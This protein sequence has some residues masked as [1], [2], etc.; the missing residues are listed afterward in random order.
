MGDEECEEVHGRK[1][2]VVSPQG[3]V[4]VT[5]GSGRGV[6]P[7][8][9]RGAPELKTLRLPRRRIPKARRLAR[10][11]RDSS[12]S[13][14]TWSARASPSN[15]SGR[16]DGPNLRPGW[17]A[18]P[19]VLQRDV[20]ASADHLQHRTTLWRIGSMDHA[21]GRVDAHRQLGGRFAQRLQRERSIDFVAPTAETL[22]V[23]TIV[24]LV[25]VATAPIPAVTLREGRQAGLE[26][27]RVEATD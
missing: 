19:R 14:S 17:A 3:R 18:S 5:A 16:S 13:S 22:Q 8:G 15:G 20:H 21:L 11:A 9:T 24:V 23:I 12:K 10:T 1:K 4:P 27:R 2:L 25:L 6:H 26:P 7:G